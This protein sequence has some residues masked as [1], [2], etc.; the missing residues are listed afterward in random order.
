MAFDRLAVGINTIGS[1]RDQ[2]SHCYKTHTHA[3]T[4]IHA[5]THREPGLDRY[6]WCN[7]VPVNNINEHTF[8][9]SK[10]HTQQITIYSK[11]S[12]TVSVQQT[13]NKCTST[14][15]KTE[16]QMCLLTHT[17]THTLSIRAWRG[18]YGQVGG[19]MR[20]S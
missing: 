19:S 14:T 6:T 10:Y 20:S 2:Y 5:R 15:L 7:S 13:C 4:G 1:G 16:L 12:C 8:V 17:H 11:V 9:S 18:V 3:H